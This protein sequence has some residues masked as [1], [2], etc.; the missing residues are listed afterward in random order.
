MKDS[1]IAFLV[2]LI[3][4]TCFCQENETLTVFEND[5]LEKSQKQN[6]AAVILASVGA[7]FTFIGLIMPMRV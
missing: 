3:S 6:Q 1:L 5:Y 2:L 4:T 7:T